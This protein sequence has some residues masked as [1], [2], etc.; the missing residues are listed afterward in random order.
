[1]A[2]NADAG[3]PA[4]CILDGVCDGNDVFHALN[5][6]SNVDFQ[7]RSSYPCACFSAGPEPASPV[8][9]PAASQH[10]A[11]LLRS[12]P[13][14]WPGALIDVDVFLASD[15]EALRGYQLHLDASGGKGGRLELVDISIREPSALSTPN[16]GAGL[17]PAPTNSAGAWSAFNTSTN[18]MLAGLD[19]PE[20][21]PAAAGAYL[22]T[23]TYRVAENAAGTFTIE[24]LHNNDAGDRTPGAPPRAIPQERT[25]L[26]GRYGGL[27]DL[28][29][30]P[31]VS[32]TVTP[33][34]RNRAVHPEG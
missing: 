3:G 32:V 15:V 24:V 14:V 17:K 5:C 29:N 23:F 1:L 26:F 10:A 7:G 33:A 8:A 31:P 21:I 11:L 25:F 6:F 16:A 18:Q 12:I 19:E 34:R 2:F 22:A 28:T 27:I 4:S 9:P 20:G 13:E 30:A